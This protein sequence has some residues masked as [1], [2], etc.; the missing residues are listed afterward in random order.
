MSF[1]SGRSDDG[2]IR[3]LLE[4]LNARSFGDGPSSGT[5]F[6]DPLASCYF[7]IDPLQE[8]REARMKIAGHSSAPNTL[9]EE[10]PEVQDFAFAAKSN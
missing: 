3:S 6:D 2:S 9:A 1:S 4:R 10:I 5:P 8:L 7:R